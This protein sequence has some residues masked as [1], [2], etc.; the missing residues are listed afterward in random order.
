M[1]SG[2]VGSPT[3]ASRRPIEG[4]GWTQL[5]GHA[6]SPTLAGDEAVDWIPERESEMVGTFV[7][8]AAALRSLVVVIVLLVV[9]IILSVM[10]GPL[11]FVGLITWLLLLGG[12]AVGLFLLVR[13]GNPMAAAGTI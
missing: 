12:I 7:S 11:G 8:L 4:S 10:L 1:L 9:S 6:S 3:P 13:A 2:R 5:C